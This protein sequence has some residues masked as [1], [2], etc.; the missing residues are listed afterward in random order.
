MEQ[1]NIS[2]DRML[3]VYR[4]Q[5]IDELKKAR[6]LNRFGSYDEIKKADWIPEVSDRYPYR[7]HMCN[8]VVMLGLGH[9]GQ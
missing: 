3:E 1:D 9:G 7:I 5:R 8:E 4:Q 6:A 2:D